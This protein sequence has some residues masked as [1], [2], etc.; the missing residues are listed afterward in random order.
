MCPWDRTNTADAEHELEHAR[1]TSSLCATVPITT[2]LTNHTPQLL[3]R[4]GIGPDN[5]AALL[6][7]A[8][9]NPDRLRSE[10]S[11]AALCGVS[12]PGGILR[13]DQSSPPQPL[14]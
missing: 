13:Q 14:R 4:C 7:A 5:A 2:A 11:F 9:D 1:T 6:I 3:T 10:A 8:G 12:P